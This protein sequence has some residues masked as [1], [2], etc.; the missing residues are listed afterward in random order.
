MKRQWQVRRTTVA[1]PNAQ[2]RWDRAYQLLLRCAMTGPPGTSVPPI[3]APSPLQE[4]SRA[5]SG[6]CPRLDQPSGAAADD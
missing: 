4:V 6:V 3:P 1:M 5:R 2:Q